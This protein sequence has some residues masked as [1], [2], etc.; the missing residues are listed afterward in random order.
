MPENTHWNISHI[1]TSEGI[2]YMLFPQT[3]IRSK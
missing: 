1:F 3:V 2:N